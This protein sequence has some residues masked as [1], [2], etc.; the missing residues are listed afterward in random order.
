MIKGRE[1]SELFGFTVSTRPHRHPNV[2]GKP[3]FR[4]I[5]GF[6]SARQQNAITT[7]L[8][9]FSS[10]IEFFA[11]VAFF[12]SGLAMRGI[13]PRVLPS[14]A[15]KLKLLLFVKMPNG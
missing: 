10:A 1:N 15:N 5:A 6:V 9:S 11:L 14:R 13:F 2:R 7:R 8:K 3:P 12:N 4:K